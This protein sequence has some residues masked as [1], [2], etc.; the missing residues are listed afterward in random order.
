MRKIKLHFLIVAL[1]ALT[2]AYCDASELLCETIWRNLRGSEIHEVKSLL[3]HQVQQANNPSFISNV[4]GATEKDVLFFH[5]ENAVLKSLNDIY[6]RD[7]ELSAGTTSWYKK[8]FMS[9]LEEVLEKQPQLMYADYKGL[10]L[11][12]SPAS[13]KLRRQLSDIYQAAGLKLEGLLR[14][15]PQLTPLFESDHGLVSNP[16][17]W[18]LAGTGSTA[19]RAAIAARFARYRSDDHGKTVPVLDYSDPTV[20][21]ELDFHVLETEML[22]LTLEKDLLP[23]QSTSYPILIPSEI[24][25]DWVLSPPVFETLRKVKAN[26]KQEYT[27]KVRQLFAKRFKVLLSDHE[28]EIL[29]KYFHLIDTFS[30]NIFETHEIVDL[31]MGGSTHGLVAVDISGQGPR[32]LYRTQLAVQRAAV[33]KSKEFAADLAVDFTREEQTI[34]SQQFQELRGRFGIALGSVFSEFPNRGSLTFSGDDGIFQPVNTM[35]L[36][37]KQNLL[38]ELTNLGT[39][40]DF[41]LTFLPQNY[42]DRSIPISQ[43]QRAEYVTVAENIEKALRVQLEADGVSFWDLKNLIIG[44]DLKPE[45]SGN[46]RIDLIIDGK[47]HEK[48]NPIIAKVAKKVLPENVVLEQIH[49]PALRRPNS[50]ERIVTVT[51]FNNPFEPAQVLVAN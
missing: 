17:A 36:A 7:K 24:G 19:D 45:L 20:R 15:F 8:T 29:Q 41:R 43:T 33:A 34:A 4:Q 21:N 50:L 6:F 40:A 11:A 31:G 35:D 18:F 32:N 3:D 12:S 26:G 38:N 9:L 46:S 1:A 13:E 5:V 25:N 23:R 44:V 39:P 51:N 42:S 14:K 27:L 47:N 22:R 16:R 2:A 28:V 30:P 49:S 10:R 37:H 48:I